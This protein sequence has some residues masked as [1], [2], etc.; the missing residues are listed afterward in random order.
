[1]PL[2]QISY[3]KGKRKVFNQYKCEKNTINTTRYEKK[4]SFD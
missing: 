1:M 4:T 2:Q 3:C